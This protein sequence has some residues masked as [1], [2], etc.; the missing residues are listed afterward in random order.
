MEEIA[1]C[2]QFEICKNTI[3]SYECQN[4]E[5][6]FENGDPDRIVLSSRYTLEPNSRVC[7]DI[8]GQLTGLGLADLFS[9]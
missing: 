3:G 7:V 8:A 4:Q 1:N 6:I 2:T 5:E 9:S